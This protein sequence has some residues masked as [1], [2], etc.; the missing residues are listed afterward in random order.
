M[1]SYFEIK[2]LPNPEII[3][4]TVMSHLMQA[5]HQLL[6]QFGGNIALDFPGYGRHRTLGGIIRIVSNK[7]DTEAL[8]NKVLRKSIFRDYAL[9]TECDSVPERV[10]QHIKN[11]RHRKKGQSHLKRLEKRLRSQGLWDE[12]IKAKAEAKFEASK[13]M[14]HVH[15][16]SSSTGE[17]F[18]LAVQR[19]IQTKPE[20]GKFNGFGLSLGEATVPKF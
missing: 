13:L 18:I 8:Y 2:A 5:L 1:D 17:N 7:E 19:K 9:V 3:E 16:K 20:M 4:S 11:T 12:S 14:P 6:P 15:L 10:S